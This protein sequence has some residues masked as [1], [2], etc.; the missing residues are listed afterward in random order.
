MR[1]DSGVEQMLHE[2]PH[3]LTFF[4][5]EQNTMRL[6]PRHRPIIHWPLH[7]NWLERKVASGVCMCEEA[8]FE[9]NQNFTEQA[10]GA[11]NFVTYFTINYNFV[12]V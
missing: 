10:N 8:Q 7:W 1:C 11:T 2:H 6:R 9:R 3:T 12:L 4:M 5:S